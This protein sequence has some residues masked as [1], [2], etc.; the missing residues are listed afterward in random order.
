MSN[1]PSDP[2]NNNSGNTIGG[3]VENSFNVTHNGK[4]PSLFSKLFNSTGT[5]IGIIAGI[6]AIFAFFGIKEWKSDPPNEP[7]QTIN[8]Q[9]LGTWQLIAANDQSLPLNEQQLWRFF[10]NGAMLVTNDRS[11]QNGGY[12]VIGTRIT[13]APLGVPDGV[14]SIDGDTMTITESVPQF[15][16]SMQ[17]KRIDRDTSVP[18]DDS[19]N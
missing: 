4:E 15:Y 9:I 17:L 6:I 12:R 10:E 5:L 8:Y 16:G 3:N 7:E 11:S 1:K 18:S 14:V 19:K 13:M 2:T